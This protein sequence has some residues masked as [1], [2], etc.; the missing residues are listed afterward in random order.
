MCPRSVVR[1][2]RSS[3][4]QRSRGGSE[5]SMQ[6]TAAKRTKKHPF[7]TTGKGCRK[8]PAW[9]F[10]GGPSLRGR[11]RGFEI[12]L[13]AEQSLRYACL[14]DEEPHNAEQQ[15]HGEEVGEVVVGRSRHR[16]DA[17]DQRQD[18]GD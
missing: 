12:V 2:T 4:S 11:R 13:D 6:L 17:A 5:K 10:S 14:Q 7:P 8:P 18:H 9:G 15:V 1:L 16:I 3:E